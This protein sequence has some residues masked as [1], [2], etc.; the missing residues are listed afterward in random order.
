M[1]DANAKKERSDI[2]STETAKDPRD[3]AM[4]EMMGLFK[5]SMGYV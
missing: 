1:A 3:T 2:L 4:E 5:E